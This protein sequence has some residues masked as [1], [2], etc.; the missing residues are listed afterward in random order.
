M[1]GA[2]VQLLVAIQLPQTRDFCMNMSCFILPLLAKGFIQ[3]FHWWNLITGLPPR[4]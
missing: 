4:G 1:E 3:L 2:E